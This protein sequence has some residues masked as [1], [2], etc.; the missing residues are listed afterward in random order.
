[1]KNKLFCLFTLLAV[2]ASSALAQMQVKGTVIDDLGE[3]LMTARV[4]ETGTTNTVVTDMDGNFSITMQSDKNTLTFSFVGFKKAVLAPK[5]VMNVQLEEDNI[6]NEMVVVGYTVEKKADLTGAVAVVDTKAL[7]TASDPDPIRALQ[8]KVP[9]MTITTNGS[10]SG[11]GTI[12]I[13]GIG[14]FNASNSPLIVIDGMPTQQSLNSLN[15]ADIES[16]QVLKDAAS[17]S[18]YGSR[19]AN[20]VIIIT[21]KKGAKNGDGKI[22]VDF[23]ANWTAQSYNKQTMMKLSNTAEYATAMAQAALNDGMD[24]VAYA[25]NYGLNLNAATGTPI[26]VWNPAT[27][28]Y[29]NYTVNGLYDGYINSKKTMRYSNTD[30]LDAISRTGFIQNYDLSMSRGGDKGSTLFTLGYKKNDGILKNTDFENLSGRLN[31]TYNINKIVSVGENITIT[32]TSQ[33]DCAPMENALKM[34][35]TVP[36]FEEDGE[37]FAGPV[38][39]MSDRHN[40]LRELEWNK[41]NRLNI[42][43]IFGNGYIDIKPVKGLTLRSN[44]GIDYDNAFIHSVNKTFHSDIV[45]NDVP[46]TTL[47]HA[48]EMRWNWTNT[49]TYSLDFCENHH[50]NALAGVETYK[51]TRI[52]FSAYSE[53]FDEETLN[54]MWPDAAT[55]TKRNNGYKSGYA[56]VSLFGKLDYNWDERVLA[57]FTIRRDGSS[58]FGKN[59][60]YATFPAFTLGYRLAKDL[61]GA[62]SWLDDLKLRA[63][64]GATGN[65]D[66]SNSA[67]YNIYFADYGNDRVTSTA[68]DLYLQGSGIFPSG[69]RVNQAASANLKWET[70]YQWNAGLDFMMLKQRLFGNVDFYVK[71]IKDMLINPAYLAALG[72]GGASWANGPSSRNTGMEFNLGWR[73]NLKCG[74]GYKINA[75]LDFFRNKVTDLPA[76]AT[77]SY[78]HTTRQNII[79]AGKPFGSRTGYVVDGLFQTKEEVL[80]SGQENARVGG[81]KYRDLN[82]D[83]RITVD[84]ETWIFNPV[85]NFSYGVNFEFTY[86]DFDLTMFWQGVAGVDVWNDQK[87]QTDFWSLTDAGSNKGNRLLDAWNTN[88]TSSTIPALTTDNTSNEGRSSSYFVENGSYLKLRTLQLGYNLPKKLMDKVKMERARVY[89]SGQN[90]LTIK[91]GSLTCSD[92]ENPNWAYPTTSSFTF[93]VQLGL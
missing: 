18:I 72:E 40:P 83:G 13:R 48:N 41:D 17:A 75:N 88:N 51:D 23:N 54:Y 4:Q 15:T 10:P 79:E 82:G 7:K 26:Q 32:H 70:T 28:Q 89:F 37:T 52:D 61:K 34:A 65:Q 66:I 38:G 57:S 47:S 63:S 71:D 90:L 78:A 64:W 12:R 50:L 6:L 91:S 29:V 67:R 33:V 11:T 1:M 19:A 59:N 3:P 8:G 68:Y 5:A 55:G 27:S 81:L 86:K 76:T 16:M 20:G 73:D 77:G 44:F 69:Y 2:C 25:S 24:P 45:N 43:R 87:Y 60:K 85:P 9:G 39:G 58:R 46:S 21:T 62:E 14:S 74:L 42:W 93:G 80:A 35:P 22:K 36:V 56:L 31:S 53:G 49:A 92:P 30:W 84:D